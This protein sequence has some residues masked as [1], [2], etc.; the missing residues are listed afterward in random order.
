MRLAF[1]PAERRALYFLLT[2]LILAG[3][4]RIYQRFYPDR[5]RTY[6]IAVDTVTV[7]APAVNTAAERKLDDG[8]DPNTAPQEDLEL[9]PGVGPSLARAIIAD[10]EEHG[11]Y[12]SAADLERVPGIGPRTVARMAE[13]LRFP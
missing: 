9:L 11:R 8:I 7:S 13:H 3:G 2:L 4:V 1:T 12:S 10:R 6:T 5:G